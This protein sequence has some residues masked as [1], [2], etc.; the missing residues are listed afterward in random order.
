MNVISIIQVH[1]LLERFS[2]IFRQAKKKSRI[3]NDVSKFLLLDHFHWNFEQSIC[4]CVK[5]ARSQVFVFDVKYALQ[6]RE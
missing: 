3:F 5:S 4:N 2:S 1:S 6:K